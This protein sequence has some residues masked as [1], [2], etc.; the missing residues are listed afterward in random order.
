MSLWRDAAHQTEAQYYATGDRWPVGI[1]GSANR[2]QYCP[3]RPCER[4]HA[5][6]DVAGFVVPNPPGCAF[7]VVHVSSLSCR[8]AR[9]GA[10]DYV[11]NAPIVHPLTKARPQ[12]SYSAQKPL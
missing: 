8:G 9:A 2:E 5:D 6:R 11:E 10:V 3:D 1:P 7:Q 4:W 12:V